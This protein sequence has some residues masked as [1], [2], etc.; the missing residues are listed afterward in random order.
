MS[1][2]MESLRDAILFSETSDAYTPQERLQLINELRTTSQS[3]IYH[4]R[5]TLD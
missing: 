1:K 3:F 2:F 5:K 4:R